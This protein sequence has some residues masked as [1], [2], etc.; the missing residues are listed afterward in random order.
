MEIKRDNTFKLLKGKKN[1]HSRIL[2]PAK[3]SSKMEKLSHS[4]INK[5]FKISLVT[6]MPYKKSYRESF[7]QK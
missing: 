2:D 1:C 5:N 7:R 4:W 6:E 3:I